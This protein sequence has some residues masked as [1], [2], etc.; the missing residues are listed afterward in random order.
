MYKFIFVTIALLLTIHGGFGFWAPCPGILAPVHISSADCTDVRCTVAR[1]GQLIAEAHLVPEKV[2]NHL[3][4]SFSTTFLGLRIN[5]TVPEHLRNA[6]TQFRGA[7]CPTVPGQTYIW[8][9]NAPIET[10]Y[11]AMPNVVVR[12]EF[13][14]L[15]FNFLKIFSSLKQFSESFLQKK[16]SKIIILSTFIKSTILKQFFF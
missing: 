4:V 6:C 5:F 7:G 16:N 1:G 2:H 13:F 9:L 12:G 14:F 3:E 10:H 15:F 11:P 8:D